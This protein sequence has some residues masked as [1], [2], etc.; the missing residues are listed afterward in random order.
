M[1][2][3]CYVAIKSVRYNFIF[4]MRVRKLRLF[5]GHLFSN[6]VK[7]ML[8][9][10]DAQSYVLV[11][12]CKEAGSIHLFKLVGKLT[13][14]CVTLKRNWIW[15]ILELGWKEVSVTLNGNKI[16]LPTLV[17]IPFR[18][19]YST[20]QLVSREPLLLHKMLKLGMSWFA[21][22]HSN[23]EEEVLPEIA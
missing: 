7:V 1:M 15:D 5:R 4:S 3:N 2:H 13:P 11:K 19:K 18:D 20:R 10:S 21:L 8:F 16:N 14:E 12:L 17:I 23:T 6:V 22:K 9:V